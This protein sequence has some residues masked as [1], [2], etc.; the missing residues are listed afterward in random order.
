MSPSTGT[1]LGP[2]EILTLIGVGGM[3]EPRAVSLP[4]ECRDRCC[5]TVAADAERTA[6]L[7]SEVR[8]LAL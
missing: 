3:G 1:R 4:V 5:P 6:R 2:Y 7:D 8:A